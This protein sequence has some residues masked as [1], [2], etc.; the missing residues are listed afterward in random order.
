MTQNAKKCQKG[1]QT[2]L[3]TPVVA[4][5]NDANREFDGITSRTCRAPNPGNQES[6]LTKVLTKRKS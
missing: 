5:V 6:D 3:D 4:T 1:L 2:G